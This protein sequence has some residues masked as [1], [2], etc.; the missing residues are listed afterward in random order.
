MASVTLDDMWLHDATDYSS[1]IR[2]PLNR[3]ATIE[4]D[5][6]GE[7]RRYA[8]GRLRFIRRPGDKDNLTVSLTMVPQATVT[9]IKNWSGKL[10]MFRD[11]KGRKLFG[12]YST[13]NMSEEPGPRELVRNVTFSFEEITESEEV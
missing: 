3:M 1:Y 13:V 10:L 8:G 4:G 9:A 11:P 5:V 7:V 6:Q 2:I 12:Q